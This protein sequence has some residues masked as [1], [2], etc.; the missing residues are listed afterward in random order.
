MYSTP[1]TSTETSPIIPT[2]NLTSSTSTPYGFYD[3][4]YPP[5][6]HSMTS[7]YTSPNQSI[8]FDG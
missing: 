3:P 5:G 8:N 1:N 7:S 4:Y 6:Y 2:A